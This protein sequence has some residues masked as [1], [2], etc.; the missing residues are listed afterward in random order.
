MIPLGRFLG[1]TQPEDAQNSVV[2]IDEEAVT[3]YFGQGG[4]V[5]STHEADAVVSFDKDGNLVSVTLYS[6]DSE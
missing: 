3:V 6:T 2:E 1:L 4:A 5:V